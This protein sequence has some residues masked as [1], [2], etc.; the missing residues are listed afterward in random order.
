MNYDLIYVQN[1]QKEGCYD[2]VDTVPKLAFLT[3]EKQLLITK[4][5]VVV[6]TTKI[7][8][9]AMAAGV[10]CIIRLVRNIVQLL[11]DIPVSF[12]VNC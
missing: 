12:G 7:K 9:I 3:Q 2:H 6:L 1:I 10:L 11:Q 8:T 4:P 5:L